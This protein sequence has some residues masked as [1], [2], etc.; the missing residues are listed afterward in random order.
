[1]SVSLGVVRLL[2][3]TKVAKWEAAGKDVELQPKVLAH[4]AWAD[5]FW[6]C[7]VQSLEDLS[8]RLTD[9]VAAALEQMGV[10][11]R[12]DE[13]SFVKVSPPHD[14]LPS[15]E[16][17]QLMEFAVDGTCVRLFGATVQIGIARSAEL[18]LIRQRGA[19]TICGAV[20]GACTDVPLRGLA[21]C[22]CACCPWR[23]CE[24]PLCRVV[25]T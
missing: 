18:D 1:M 14:A 6:F 9:F 22:I 17:P 13:C 20:F 7:Y 4:L 19:L 24:D 25:G 23:R 5:D 3:R 16:W 2:G 15:A 8:A 12:G 10:R 11:V 21:C